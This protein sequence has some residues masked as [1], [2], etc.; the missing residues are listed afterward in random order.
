M[1]GKR[2]FGRYKLLGK[3]GMGQ[4]YKAYDTALDRVVAVKILSTHLSEDTRFRERFR[5]EAH[6]T[7]RL[8]EPHII[9]IPLKGKAGALPVIQ[10]ADCTN[11]G[12][13]IDVCSK[14]VFVFTHRFDTRR[15]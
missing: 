11:C 3:G 6:T 13:C 7:A 9:P 1:E 15:D 8:R 2:Q 10:T 5:R 4:V 12:R 14:D